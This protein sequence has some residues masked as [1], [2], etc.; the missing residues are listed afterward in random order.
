M[1]AIISYLSEM[2][3][4]DLP[5][6]T[7]AL[8]DP[9]RLRILSAL[10]SREL[11]ACH[12][13][14]LLSLAP[15]TVSKHMDILRR[16]GLVLARRDGKWMHYRL[17][18]RDAP[19]L[20]RQ[21]LAWLSRSLHLD[22]ESRTQVQADARRLAAILKALPEALCCTQ[23]KPARGKTARTC[24]APGSCSCAPATPAARRSPKASRA[25]SRGSG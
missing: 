25:T 22:D 3:V 10:R 14:D 11:C 17:P 19:P 16:A 20:I 24:C 15:S 2:I 8:S 9:S 23:P 4:P 1:L 21:T 5:S 6:L 7:S 18:G 12:L 13:I